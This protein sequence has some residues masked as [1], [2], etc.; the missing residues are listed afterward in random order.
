MKDRQRDL[1]VLLRNE[2]MSEQA[3]EQEVENLN[4]ILLEVE[5]T[6]SFCI[7]HELVTRHR[8]TS[9][10]NRIIRATQQIVLPSFYFLLNKN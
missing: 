1:L 5:S 6:E 2:F 3:I 10:K 8:I 9:R 4:S 7:S